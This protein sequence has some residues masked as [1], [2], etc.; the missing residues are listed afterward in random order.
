M[1][2]FGHYTQIDVSFSRRVAGGPDYWFVGAGVCLP[3]PLGRGGRRC[4]RLAT[5]PPGWR[6]AARRPS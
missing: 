3:S 2:P 1:L 6:H 4:R 5:L